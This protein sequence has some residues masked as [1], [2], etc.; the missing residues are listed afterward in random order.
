MFRK[1][2]NKSTNN[3]NSLPKSITMKA[4]SDSNSKLHL[5]FNRLYSLPNNKV[6]CSLSNKEKYKEQLIVLCTKTGHPQQLVK[7]SDAIKPFTVIDGKYLVSAK[8]GNIYLQNLQEMGE[9]TIKKLFGNCREEGLHLD[10]YKFEVSPYGDQLLSFHVNSLEEKHQIAIWDIKTLRL[11]KKI[12]LDQEV[13]RGKYV[14]D[15][16]FNS[17]DMLIIS[18]S[19]YAVSR[20]RGMNF[21]FASIDLT[22]FEIKHLFTRQE[23]GFIR[24]ISNKVIGEIYWIEINENF[25][26][27]RLMKKVG[28]HDPQVLF[29]TESTNKAGLQLCGRPLKRIIK[30][31]ICSVVFT[32]DGYVVALENGVINFFSNENKLIHTTTLDLIRLSDYGPTISLAWNPYNGSIIAMSECQIVEIDVGYKERYCHLIDNHLR[33]KDLTGIINEYLGFQKTV[34]EKN[35]A[36]IAEEPKE[37]LRP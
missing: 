13:I 18:G 22:T 29:E 20:P 34:R 32:P 19:N 24:N 21:W 12:N 33:N 35:S 2:V 3:Q 6:L 26:Q 23:V 10:I 31:A 27:Y 25:T 28:E 4:L 11:V 9:S 5:H 17:S 37:N 36:K 1:Q 7:S 16:F 30:N 15:V 14:S 8:N